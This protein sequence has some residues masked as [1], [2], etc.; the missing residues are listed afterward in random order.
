MWLLIGPIC[1]DMC[2]RLIRNPEHDDKQP[3]GR[4]IFLSRVCSFQTI[5]ENNLK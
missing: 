4:Q 2:T 3:Q 5:N 1:V